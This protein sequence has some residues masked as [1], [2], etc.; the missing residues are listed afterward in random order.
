MTGHPSFGELLREA[1]LA[2]GLS[3]EALAERA[4]LSREA[5]SLL[6]RGGR[7]KP[8][9]DTIALLIRSL[10]L[11][12]ADRARLAAS[13]PEG[14]G[15]VSTVGTARHLPAAL[16]V[17]L[18]SFVG[19]EREIAQV[20]E[21]LLASRLLTLTGIGG[22][23]KTRLALEV[24]STSHAQFPDGIGLVELAPLTEPDLVPH[25]VA[26]TLGV[27]EVPGQSILTTLA[28]VIGETWRLVILDNCEHLVESCAHMAEVLLQACP[29]LQL[30]VTSRVPLR[31][32][33]EVVWRVPILTLPRSDD[34]RSQ[35]YL[36]EGTDDEEDPPPLSLAGAE[37][38]LDAEAIRLFVE[39]A[40]AVRP[41]FALTCANVRSV[42]EICRRLDGIPLAIE[43]AAARV[44]ALT[45]EQI[46]RH[47]NDR[48]R[49]LTTGSRTALPRHQTLRATF[50]WSHDLLSEKEQVLLRRLAV[51]VGGCTLDAAE[52]VCRDSVVLVEGGEPAWRSTL[53]Q[54]LSSGE[55]FVLLLEL[56]DKSLVLVEDHDDDERYTML[57]TVREYARD[58]LDHGGEPR[59]LR[60]E[61]ASYFAKLVG[62][63]RPQPVQEII[64]RVVTLPLGAVAND[65][66]NLRAALGYFL[67]Q[68]DAEAGLALS[69]RIFHYWNLR[70]PREEGREWLRRFLAMPLAGVAPSRTAALY[71]AGW[72]ALNQ[73]DLVAAQT[74]FAEAHAL[75]QDH[76]DLAG[77]AYAQIKLGALSALRGEIVRA[78]RE[79]EMG[80]RMARLGDAPVALLESLIHLAYLSLM[81]GT[82]TQVR[83]LLEEAREVLPRFPATKF[84]IHWVA[85]D[86]ALA[87][88]QVEDAMQ[89]YSAALADRWADRDPM[90][91]SVSTLGLAE[92]A[93]RMRRRHRAA[94]L[95]GAS[96][97]LAMGVGDQAIPEPEPVR[98]AQHARVVAAARELLGPTRFAAV[99]AQG[100][101]LKLNEVVELGRFSC[102]GMGRVG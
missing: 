98:R 83:E 14:R 97:G 8:R 99:R 1:R 82:L 25:V 59:I 54:P 19:R 76:G 9:R 53:T 85:G 7:L 15:P 52:A 70:G 21:L 3:Q 17:R 43:L 10:E 90:G 93:V 94:Q 65:S 71:A 27:R 80:A 28:T 78:Q 35:R 69:A 73:G 63:P 86:L 88:D 66:E 41:G 75:A 20:R 61:H 11:S 4:G 6:E 47:L 45:A 96:E 55:V 42:V 24:A 13:L 100:Q 79:L 2:R 38:A 46:A 50:D 18:T 77:S 95:L 39:R 48:F 74:A 102:S 12:P 84:R 30:L 81:H 31:I 49:L 36:P 22:I 51:F 26:S 16:P 62:G 57:E 89:E 33:A 101:R 67:D 60:A 5:I 68:D 64:E 23:G 32:G 87:E 29:R 40:G 91:V 34:E 72:L 58:R 44:A 37:T 56:V 92:V